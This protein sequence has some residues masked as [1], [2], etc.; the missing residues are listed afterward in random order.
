MAIPPIKGT[1]KIKPITKRSFS[2]YGPWLFNSL[3][4]EL[5]NLN[6]ILIDDFKA[7]LVKYLKKL[8]DEP[9]EHS[10]PEDLGIN[11]RGS[12]PPICI[13]LQVLSVIKD[14]TFHVLR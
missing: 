1:G 3:P 6:D 9:K 14:L 10:R 12:Q 5:R 7:K 13:Q 11:L 4:M 8:P 2:I